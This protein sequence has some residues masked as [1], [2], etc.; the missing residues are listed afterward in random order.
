MLCKCLSFLAFGTFLSCYKK[1]LMVAAFYDFS[2]FPSP[3]VCEKHFYCFRT[4]EE[5]HGLL[6]LV[7]IVHILSFIKE[8]CSIGDNKKEFV[9]QS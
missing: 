9:E 7:S 1:S 6:K 2:F 3:V 5:V 4:G 8:Y